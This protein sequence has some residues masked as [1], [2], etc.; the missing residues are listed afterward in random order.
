MKKGSF[1]ADQHGS[2]FS[3]IPLFKIISLFNLGSKLI[4]IMEPA[5]LDKNRKI[6]AFKA[7]T[8]R[9]FGPGRTSQYKGSQAVKVLVWLTYLMNCRKT[10]KITKKC[11]FSLSTLVGV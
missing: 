6:N 10:R 3:I 4:M 2:K 7:R 1:E 9:S 5:L 11:I 8:L